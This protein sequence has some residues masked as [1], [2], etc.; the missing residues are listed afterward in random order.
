MIRSHRS[1]IEPYKKTLGILSKDR[2]CS[3]SNVHTSII[4]RGHASQPDQRLDQPLDPSRYF[5][6]AMSLPPER[7]AQSSTALVVTSPNLKRARTQQTPSPPPFFNMNTVAGEDSNLTNP[8]L[9]LPRPPLAELAQVRCERTF[10]SSSTSSVG[11]GVGS[12]SQQT[13]FD[14]STEPAPHISNNPRESVRRLKRPVS[15]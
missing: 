7:S 12:V 3:S 11:E 4:G 1:T 6:E 2:E 13:I 14:A 15:D 8:T 9:D 5:T 10:T